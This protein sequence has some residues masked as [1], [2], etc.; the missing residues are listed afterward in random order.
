MEH[1]ARAQR[2]RNHARDRRAAHR[3]ATVLLLVLGSFLYF[4]F[5]TLTTVGYG[6]YAPLDDI[7]RTLANM[8]ALFG[9]LYLVTVIGVLVSRIPAA[10]RAQV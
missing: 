2:L 10:R 4:S 3:Y 6:D 7:A 5:V 8:E 9:Q 1:R